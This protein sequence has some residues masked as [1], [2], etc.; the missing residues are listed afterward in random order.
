MEVQIH[1]HQLSIRDNLRE[2]VQEKLGKLEKIFPDITSAEIGF[3][4]R[5][6][7]HGEDKYKVEVTLHC[8][9]THVRAE[10]DSTSP[11]AAVDFVTEKLEKQLKRYKGRVYRNLSRD[12]KRHN[13]H[14]Q[15]SGEYFEE[16]VPEG[17]VIP[18]SATANGVK[19]AQP[20]PILVDDLEDLDD[21]DGMPVIVRSKRFH[22]KPMGPEEAA[23]QLELLG[24]DFY[25]FANPDSGS[26][27]VVY[28]RKDGNFGLIEPETAR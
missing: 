1:S 5:A 27:N 19:G 18:A 10:D 14:T 3:T 28:R 26:M 21:A 25:V 9:G 23:L 22:M 20:E 24:H 2:Y 13:G 11:F 16:E 12:V 6:K 4:R 15:R 7:N 17:S 8:N